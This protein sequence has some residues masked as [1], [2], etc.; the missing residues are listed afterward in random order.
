MSR[1]LLQRVERVLPEVVAFRRDLH[2]HPELSRQEHETSRKVRERLQP[3]PGLD[4]LPPL[5]ETDVVAVLNADRDGSCIAIRADMD[6]LPIDEQ[7]DVT[8][9]STVPGVMH[10]CGHDGHTAIA[11]GTAMVLSE[12]RDK[13][14]GKVKFIFQPDEEN[15]GG[16]GVLCERGVLDS[17]KV[18]AAVA[19]HGWPNDA[20]GSIATTVGPASAANTPIE[21]TVC[22]QG[23]HGAYPHRGVD[24]I[25]VAAHIITALQSI[26]S[27]TLDPLDSGVVTI[28]Q[29]MAGSACNVIPSECK[30]AGTLRFLHTEAGEQIRQRVQ[31]IV[32]NT[33]KA[34]GAE[35][36]VEFG[37]G[38][39]PIHND[40]RITQHVEDAARDVVGEDNLRTGLNL[41]LGVE[42]FG[43]YAQRVPASM[44]RLGLRP[45][46]KDT[47]PGLHSPM[48]DF[49]DDA[50]DVGIQM[51]CEIVSQFFAS[52]SA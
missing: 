37:P 10:A 22:G 50:I 32:E 45:K 48:F 15:G 28:G 52:R 7:T 5:M 1:K 21:I 42:D 34:H 49:N 25:V 2:A 6:A 24:P 35:A 4:V 44:F 8:H 51:F 14:P 12:L 16:G 29:I 17:P 18:D 40:A 13:L 3:L 38:Y 39:P 26:V 27:R 43:F 31:R 41:S 46:G 11:L 19:L 23:A 33:A 30:M 47:Y 20:V 36:T 9:K